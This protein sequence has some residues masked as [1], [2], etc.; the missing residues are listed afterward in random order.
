[1]MGKRNAIA[2]LLLALCSAGAPGCKKSE[3]EEQQRELLTPAK[4]H[5][6]AAARKRPTPAPLFDA[7]GELLPSDKKVGEIV[8]PVG[9]DLVR[10]RGN[11]W[12][13]KTDRVHWEAI[14]K[15]FDKQV[16]AMNYQPLA[17]SVLFGNAALKQDPY[18]KQRFTVLVEELKGSLTASR[19]LIR[20]EEEKRPALTPEQADAKLEEQ[21][22]NAI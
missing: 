4:A 17:G 13:F 10:Q 22:R 19:V 21:R 5:Q 1:M 12:R 6:V 8:L 15:Y 14:V 3:S 18:T 7:Q 11:E 2:L 16:V 9:L 20:I